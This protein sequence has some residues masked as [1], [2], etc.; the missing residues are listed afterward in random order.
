MMPKVLYISASFFCDKEVQ[1]NT[2]FIPILAMLSAIVLASLACQAG[3]NQPAPAT[4]TQ[5]SEPTATQETTKPTSTPR[6]TQ[7]ANEQPP[8]TAAFSNLACFG[9]TDQGIV[10][11]TEQG[12]QIYNTQN[13]QL[14]NDYI[15]AL[16]TCPNGTLVAAHYDGISLFDGKEW[17]SIPR[18]NYT[19]ANALACDQQGNLWVAHFRGV[20][21]YDGN[22]TQFNASELATGTSASDLVYD[23]GIAPDGKVWVVTSNSVASFEDNA[24][25][26]YQEGQGFD[27]KMFFKSLTFDTEGHPIVAHNDGISTF[28]DGKWTITKSSDFLSSAEDIAV[29][30][31]GRI[32]IGTITQGLYMI[33]KGK[34]KNLTF[35]NSDLS[36][37]SINNLSVDS[38]GRV[39]VATEYGLSVLTNDSWV[40]FRMDNSD[41][42]VNDIRGVAILADIPSLPALQE[43]P[44]GSITGQVKNEDGTPI[45][46]SDVEIC[47][48]ILGSTYFGATPCSDQPFYLTSKTDEQ[49]KFSFENVPPGYYTLVMK[50]GDQWAQLTGNI[51]FVSEQVLV[52]PGKTTEVGDITIKK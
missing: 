40:V 32:W 24:W 11:L 26:I 47:V 16:A 2:R 50:I 37:N 20:S 9:T 3:G 38:Q 49:G 1:M 17:E 39:W 35:Q 19:T 4:P 27:K 30:A 48:E 52:N 10:C 51:G 14:E 5:A 12:W 21:R 28:K 31:Q 44:T 29:D 41:L 46:N 43:K 18:G 6:P 15:N 22:W 13:S 33:E 23:V 8:T 7:P 34:W 25:T 45:A 42:P 36:S